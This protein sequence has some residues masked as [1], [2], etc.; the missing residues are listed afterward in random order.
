MCVSALPA[1]AAYIA[2]ALSAAH[3]HSARFGARFGALHTARVRR[4]GSIASAGDT[5]TSAAKT[6]RRTLRVCP[7]ELAARLLRS[8]RPVLCVFVCGARC[9]CTLRRGPRPS[10]S[11]GGGRLLQRGAHCRAIPVDSNGRRARVY[12]R[13]SERVCRGGGGGGCHCHC[14]WRAP[15]VR[16]LTQR[17][18]ALPFPTVYRILTLC[19]AVAGK[20]AGGDS[21][22]SLRALRPHTYTTART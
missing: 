12:S 15:A 6:T 3:A 1:A 18:R 14:S 5:Q 11:G 8:R 10:H 21:A 22:R 13:R 7:L 4:C 20:V 9:K 17:K 16:A 2:N 19:T